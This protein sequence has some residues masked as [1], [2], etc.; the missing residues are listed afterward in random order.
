MECKE[1]AC[2]S[3]TGNAISS[4]E[5]HAEAIENYSAKISKECLQLFK[6]DLAL[7]VFYP[8]LDHNLSSDEGNR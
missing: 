7:D 3:Y 4:S 2:L 1:V 8:F 5:T 6:H